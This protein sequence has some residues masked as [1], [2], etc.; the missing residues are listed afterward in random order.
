VHDWLV[1]SGAGERIPA[2]WKRKEYSDE[3]VLRDGGFERLVQHTVT[4]QHQWTL[5][6]IIGFCRATSCAPRAALRVHFE[7]FEADVQHALLEAD[8]IGL[9][10]QEISFGT[11]IARR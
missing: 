4:L 8:R 6:T 11:L 5:D 10:E 7:S 2:G 9:Y 1:R 3:V